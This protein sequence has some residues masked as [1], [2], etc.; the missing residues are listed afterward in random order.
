M[1]CRKNVELITT[2]KP[3]LRK[4]LFTR[5][6]LVTDATYDLSVYPFYDNWVQLKIGKMN[7][8]MH[9]RTHAFE[10]ESDGTIYLLIGHAYNPYNGVY[11]ENELLKSYAKADNKTEVLN[12]WTGV[13]TLVVMCDDFIEIWGDCA[14][15]QAAYYGFVKGHFYVS[16]HA[17]LIG[18]LCDLQQSKYVQSMVKYPFWHLY[19]MFLPGDLSQ[20]DGVCRVVP[21]TYATFRKSDGTFAVNRFYPTRN[22]A[23]CKTE[24]EYDATIDEICNLLHANMKLISKK[25]N[26]PAISMSGGMDSKATFACA[27]GLYDKFEYYSYDTMYGDRPDVAAAKE[28]ASAAGVQH[29]IYVVSEQDADFP[30]V[31]QVRVIMEH[32]WG[33]IGR[34]NDNDVRKR[35]FFMDMPDFDVEVKSWVSEVGRAN[36]YKKFGLKKMP[37]HLSARQ[38]TTMYKF[39]SYNRRQAKETDRIFS[40]YIAKTNANRIFNLDASDMYLWEFRYGS[41]GGLV[42]TS[43]HRMSYDI[44]IPY[45]NR[46]L[47][48]LFLRLPLEKRIADTPHYDIIRKMNPK[49]DALN[50]TVTNYNETKRR[51]YMERLYYFVNN[52]LPF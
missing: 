52:L 34:V 25:W 43:E 35:M 20:F 33:D 42:I 48:E 24:Q 2:K 44:T 28:I 50:I 6:Y 36:Y 47:M 14:G 23:M 21:N 40:Q 9:N 38:M 27:N 11:D 13:F 45:N 30:H 39:F 29:K 18:D 46:N 7:F 19:G 12:Q 5:G 41:W 1:S 37:K 32:N 16:S 3:S 31:D 26:K 8:Y 22:I 10:F 4:Y 49:V 51:M 15:M 17:Q